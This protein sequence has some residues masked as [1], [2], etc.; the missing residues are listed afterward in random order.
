M[1]GT[2][3]VLTPIFPYS[4]QPESFAGSTF[5]IG[6]GNLRTSAGPRQSG[7]GSKN[8]SSQGFGGCGAIL[9]GFRRDSCR[10]GDLRFLAVLGEPCG[11][12]GGWSG[13]G[14]DEGGNEETIPI[15]RR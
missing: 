13:D 1:S 2:E 15:E 6:S 12:C 3:S 7:E 8:G 5:Q 4:P 14:S 11:A 9:S 10:V